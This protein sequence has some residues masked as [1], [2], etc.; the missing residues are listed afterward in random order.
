MKLFE[1]IQIRLR[2]SSKK[3]RVLSQS[4]LMSFPYDYNNESNKIPRY[5]TCL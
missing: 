5:L 3:I 1:N 4:I 2:S